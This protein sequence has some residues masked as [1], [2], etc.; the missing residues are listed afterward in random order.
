LSFCLTESNTCEK[1]IAEVKTKI[2]E[3]SFVIILKF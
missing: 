1:E 3:I 2:N